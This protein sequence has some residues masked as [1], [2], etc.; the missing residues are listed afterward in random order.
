MGNRK[1]TGSNKSK[2]PPRLHLILYTS[3]QQ[4]EIQKA[5]GKTRMGL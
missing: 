2:R 1:G 4:E 3:F 5:T